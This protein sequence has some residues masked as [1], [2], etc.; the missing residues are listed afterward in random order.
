MF[1]IK[2]IIK[3]FLDIYLL[4]TK[5]KLLYVNSISVNCKIHPK[6]IIYGSTLLGRIS[7][8]QGC[9]LFK[10]NL[11]GDIKI[12]ENSSLWGPG[13]EIHS[14]RNQIIIGK[15]CSIAR[16][17]SIQESNHRI[18]TITSYNI[19][20]N[21]F[22]QDVLNDMS[23]RGAIEIGNDVWI[24]AQSIILSGVK[25]GNGAVIGANSTVTRDVPAY[26]IVG[27]NP[28]RFIKYRF[29]RRII[30]Q[31]ENMAWWDWPIEK[32]IKNGALFTN[33]ITEDTLRKYTAQ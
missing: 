16:Y 8:G 18:D 12:G 9:R 20:R 7:V 24:G 32:I 13:I 11:F 22:K 19:Q 33:A 23:S 15:F 30:E 10:A 2:K 6:A 5:N 26:A 17:V 14:H 31:I 29:E 27:G 1:T 4:K 28:A 3:R 25:V 21:I